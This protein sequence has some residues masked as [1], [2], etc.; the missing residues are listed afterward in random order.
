MKE[1][2]NNEE[3]EILRTMTL[4]RLTFFTLKVVD[5]KVDMLKATNEK[6][7]NKLKEAHD[8]NVSVRNTFDKLYEYLLKN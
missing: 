6:N 7:Y 4:E 8:Y 5:L 1:I 3:L 2:F